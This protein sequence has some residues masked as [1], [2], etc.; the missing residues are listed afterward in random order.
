MGTYGLT[1]I[2]TWGGAGIGKFTGKDW[3]SFNTAYMR[4]LLSLNVNAIAF[5]LMDSVWVGTD[6]GL[7]QFNGSDQVG[8]KIYNAQNSKIPD[9]ITAITIDNKNIKW[10][11]FSNGLLASFDGQ[12]MGI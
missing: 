2:T 12:S 9:K 1:C 11:G 7:A 5:D 6:K 10:I 3:F 8:W 4:D